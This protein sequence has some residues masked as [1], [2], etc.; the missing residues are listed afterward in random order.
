MIIKKYVVN[1]MNEAMSKI[2]CELGSDAIILSERKIKKG[3]FLGIFSK[4]MI[5]VTATTG[6]PP[7]YN[8]ED[9]NIEKL[10]RLIENKNI[11]MQ[12]EKK[13]MKKDL[14]K[15]SPSLNKDENLAC[16]VREMK[17][18]LEKFTLNS[19]EEENT[20]KRRLCSRDIEEKILEK[21]IENVENLKENIEE[22]EKLR[23]VL[24][25]MIEVST[26]TLNKVTVLVGST[27]VGKTTTIAKLAGRIS[28]IEKRKVGLITIDTYRIGAVEQLRTYADIMNIPFKVVFSIKEMEK[29]VK[30]LDYCDAILIDTTGRSSKKLMQIS[31]LRAFIEKV[32]A[33]NIHLVISATTKNR[34]I[35]TIMDGYKQLNYNN[36][37]ITKLDETS[38]YGSILN[39][40]EKG[41]KPI[42]FVTTGQDVP[43][44]IKEANKDEIVELILGEDSIC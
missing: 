29:A 33:N 42:S 44:D 10:K 34:D 14:K 13:V 2:R 37:I 1:D 32:N 5:E 31:E 27:G 19:L 36:I 18:M 40:C 20:L 23:K 8:K 4:K 41:K 17:K 39:I 6:G 26:N 3:G 15:E 30:E 35:E 21:I 24:K 22:K 12:E 16:E 43:D 28:L 11:A 9:S 25:S 7:E 38:T